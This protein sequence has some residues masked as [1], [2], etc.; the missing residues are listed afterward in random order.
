MK[1]KLRL[2]MR[3]VLTV[4]MDQVEELEEIIRAWGLNLQERK[5]LGLDAKLSAPRKRRP[6][7]KKYQQIPDK[8]ICDVYARRPSDPAKRKDKQAKVLADEYEIGISTV[9]MIW[10]L[11]RPHYVRIL[12]RNGIIGDPASKLI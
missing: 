12:R 11:S 5:L 4:S 1:R 6:Y 10:N 9:A 3:Y 7:K 8:I 2:R